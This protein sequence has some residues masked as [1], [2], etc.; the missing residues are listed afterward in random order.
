MQR[1]TQQGIGSKRYFDSNSVLL[2]DNRPV[3]RGDIDEEISNQEE[4]DNSQVY[5]EGGE[6]V[7]NTDRD[8][9]NTQRGLLDTLGEA[10]RID[11]IQE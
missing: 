4:N 1:G 9:L 8:N 10:K 11:E 2:T 7:L 3:P 6:Q 5:Y